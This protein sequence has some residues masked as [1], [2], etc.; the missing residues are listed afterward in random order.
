M[1]AG[2][3]S[4]Y[5]PHGRPH[6]MD[7]ISAAGFL[8]RMSLD[9]VSIFVVL[10]LCRLRRGGGRGTVV[11]ALG[12]QG[13]AVKELVAA[14]RTRPREVTGAFLFSFLCVVVVSV[15]GVCWWCLLVVSV[16]CFEPP[17]VA[18]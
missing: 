4:C 13:R 7:T 8:E 10:R 12:R 17:R 14:F 9:F 15:P 3:V 2:I 1:N 16:G 11:V 5:A 6:L 18:G